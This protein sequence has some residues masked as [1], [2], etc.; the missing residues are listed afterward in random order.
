MGRR[1]DTLSWRAIKLRSGRLGLSKDVL[2]LQG[3]RLMKP[4]GIDGCS[5]IE[6]LGGVTGNEGV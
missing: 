6:I 1:E 4:F 2:R 3:N 5:I